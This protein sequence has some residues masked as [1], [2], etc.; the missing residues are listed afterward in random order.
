MDKFLITSLISVV[1][2]TLLYSTIVPPNLQAG[3]CVFSLFFVHVN[4]HFEFS[5]ANRDE[6]T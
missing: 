3:L 1:L 5:G 2:R 4:N 6:F